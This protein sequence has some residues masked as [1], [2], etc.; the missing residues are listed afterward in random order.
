MG[1]VFDYD[2]LILEID[3]LAGDGHYETQ[4]RLL[5]RIALACA[6]YSVI[7]TMEIGLKKS[8]VRSGTGSLGIRL[9]LGELETDGLRA[10]KP[11][12]NC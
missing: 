4:E 2:P 1:R 3:R 5:T 8:P 6:E 10:Q 9:L 12:T 11:H 7:K